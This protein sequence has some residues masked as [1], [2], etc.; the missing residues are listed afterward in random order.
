M[1]VNWRSTLAI[2]GVLI[3][4]SLATAQLPGGMAGGAPGAAAAA[5][6]PGAAA[7]AGAAQPGFFA[8]MC[9]S[10]DSCRQKLC[11]SPAGQMLN[12][13]TK[14]LSFGTGGVIPPFCPIMPSALDLAQ[15]GVAGASDAIKKDALEAQ[16]RREKVRFL[17]TVDCRYYP[18][19]IVA[20]TAAL[21]TDGSECV[22]FEA[23]LAL[24]HGC[25]CNMKTIAAL[26]ASVAGTEIDGN[27][28][29]RSVRVRC[30]AAIGL[31]R[32][33][34]CYVPPPV[35]VEPV[36]T[37]PELRNPEKIPVPVDPGPGI[38]KQNSDPAPPLLK[39]PDETGSK[40]PGKTTNPDSQKP[41]REAVEAA[42]KTLN[43][44]N[45]LLMASRTHAVIPT[46][47]RGSFYSI[48]KN[49]AAPSASPVTQASVSVAQTPSPSAAPVNVAVTQAS[50]PTPAVANSTPTR[51]AVAANTVD[52]PPIA[53]KSAVAGQS[54]PPRPLNLDQ[55]AS[56]PVVETPKVP[57]RDEQVLADKKPMEVTASPPP[58]V[59]LEL[60]YSLAASTPTVQPSA[61]PPT[62]VLTPIITQM[63]RGATPMDRHQAIRQLVKNDWQKN[64]IIVSALLMGAKNDP[65]PAVRVDCIRHLAA[66]HMSHP[67]A[68]SE[69]GPLAQDP[70]PWVRDEAA[71]ALAELKNT[72]P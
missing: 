45:A 24:S 19:A 41:T 52:S 39:L 70:D 64:L 12:G 34:S 68:I 56:T 31:E 61:V 8:R 29:E 48:V 58:V 11:A 59:V 36:E 62:P 49:T 55:A 3:T 25:C 72:A 37:K 27:P 23:A 15:P 54:I 67:Q 60:P 38:K 4:A 71:K 26:E 35:E 9:A 40:K 10:F 13:M 66:F 2:S 57:M 69:L 32:C 21:R 18:D 30:A 46:G 53:T 6:T 17:G 20:L 28:A 7:P 50:P 44:F 14:P 33:L 42:W 47:D 1:H 22:R 65:S 63:L 5:G 43:E 16:M 51:T